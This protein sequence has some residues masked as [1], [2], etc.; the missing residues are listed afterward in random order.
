MTASTPTPQS[1][2]SDFQSEYRYHQREWVAQRIGW[3]LMFVA[4]LAAC[5]GVFGGGGPLTETTSSNGA[6]HIRYERFVR[7]SA[8]TQLEVSVADRQAGRL[9]LTIDEAYLQAFEIQSITPEPAAMEADSGQ[10]TFAFDL[11]GSPASIM[12]RLKPERVGSHAGVIKVGS[13]AVMPV[14]QF[15]YP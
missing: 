6:Q 4:L 5:I 3:L 2:A 9:M 10:T 11:K 15:V 13:S 1:D 7:Y 12:L 8:L 14:K